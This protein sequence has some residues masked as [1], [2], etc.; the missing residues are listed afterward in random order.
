MGQDLLFGF[1]MPVTLALAAALLI[2]LAVVAL[3]VSL[4]VPDGSVA[5]PLETSDSSGS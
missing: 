4:R 2:L 3:L 5:D 1:P